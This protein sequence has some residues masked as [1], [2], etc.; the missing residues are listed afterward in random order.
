MLMVQE[1]SISKVC[2]I[3]LNNYVFIEMESWSA[4]DERQLAEWSEFLIFV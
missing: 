2:I 3:N 4:L 1:R